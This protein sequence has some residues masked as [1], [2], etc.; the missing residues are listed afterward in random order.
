MPPLRILHIHPTFARGD[1]TLR[2]A[3][4]MNAFGSRATHTIVSGIPGELGAQAAVDPRVK[5]HF[6]LDAPPLT[7][8]PT[9]A[10]YEAIARFMRGHDLVLTHDW[11]AMDAVLA[12]R[13]HAKD[14]P[15]LV[16]HEDALD[17]DEA[18]GRKRERGWFRRLALPGAYRLVVSS[19][20]LEDVAMKIWKQP[21]A[22]VQR[23][24]DGRAT[25]I[26]SFATLYAQA[27]GQPGVLDGL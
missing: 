7:G 15:P 20:L 19:T 18:G 23:I 26:A 10:R 2:A 12:R 22:R 4:L 27:A 14:C 24:D 25:M 17:E 5:L 8:K 3:R 16:H 13:I 11:G 1:K 6:P 21:R 9:L